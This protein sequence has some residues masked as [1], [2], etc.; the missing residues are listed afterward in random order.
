[1]ELNEYAIW[2]VKLK[3]MKRQY[4]Q[5][6]MDMNYAGDSLV[7]LELNVVAPKGKMGLALLVVHFDNAF[8]HS[9]PI[10]DTEGK[11]WQY[12]TEPQE[13]RLDNIIRYEDAYRGRM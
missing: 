8:R 3:V 5:E 10:P 6:G 12:A 2:Q 11:Q 13:V 4:A 7:L 9:T 1:M